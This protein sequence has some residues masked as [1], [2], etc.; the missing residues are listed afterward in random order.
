[1]FNVLVVCMWGVSMSDVRL[2]KS[3]TGLCPRSAHR[4][5]HRPPVQFLQLLKEESESTV[6]A[7]DSE[8]SGESAAA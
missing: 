1:M 4:M 3:V 7:F 5:S 6:V 2:L 8:L